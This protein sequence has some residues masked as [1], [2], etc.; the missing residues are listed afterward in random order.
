MI[1]GFVSGFGCSVCE[2]VVGVG[3]VGCMFINMLGV[4]LGLL[5]CLCLIID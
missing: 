5:C 3:F 1:V 4:F 2:F